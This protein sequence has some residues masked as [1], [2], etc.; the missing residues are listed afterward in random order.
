[1]VAIRYTHTIAYH[2][3]LQMQ[4]EVVGEVSPI[5]NAQLA[6]VVAEVLLAAVF[7]R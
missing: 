1:M 4:A 7:E 3:L 6:G 5:L 2:V